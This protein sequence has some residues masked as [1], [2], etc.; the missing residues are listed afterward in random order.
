MAYIGI[1]LGTS[2]CEMA[3][4]KDGKVELIPD[5][6]GDIIIPS[7]IGVDQEGNFIYGRTAKNQFI[8]RRKYTTREFKRLMGTNSKISIGDKQYSP[9]EVSAMMLAYLKKSAVSLSE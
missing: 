6:N 8:A 2:T 7:Y 4:Y 1:D 5:L 9:E 3:Y